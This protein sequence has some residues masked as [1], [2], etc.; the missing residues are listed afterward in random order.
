MLTALAADLSNGIAAL[1]R[2][3]LARFFLLLTR[4]LCSVAKPWEQ[5]Y[6]W[7]TAVSAEF[8]KQGDSEAAAGMPVE[9]FMDRSKTTVEKNTANFIKFVCCMFGARLCLRASYH[10]YVVYKFY[11]LMTTLLPRTAVLVTQMDENLT[12]FN[13]LI[14]AESATQ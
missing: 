12:R 1:A 7:S 5:S 4:S 6:K 10:R 13:K 11:T 3:V 2:T 9:P 14:E 8:F